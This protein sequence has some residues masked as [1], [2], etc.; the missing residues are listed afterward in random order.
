MEWEQEALTILDQI[1]LPPIMSAF[2][3][4]DAERRALQNGF[5]RVTVAIAKAVEKGY[6]RTFGKEATESIRKMAAGE[7]IDLPNEFFEEE[8]GQLFKIDICPAKYGA[9]TSEKRKMLLNIISPIRSKL[10]QMDAT[11]LMMSKARSPLMSH[12]VFRISLIGCPNCCMS[13]YFSDFGVICVYRIRAHEEGCTQCEACVRTCSEE[14][15]SL[16]A[17]K[18]VINYKKCVMCG[19]CVGKC[20]SGVL[21][22][23]AAGYKVMVGGSGSRRPQIA[24]TVT[25]YTDAAG[26]LGILE[27]ALQLYR[28]YPMDKKEVSFHEMIRHSGI[29]GLM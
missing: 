13:P 5:D 18:P 1:P 4:L 19:G 28:Q 2:A 9:C 6:A 8:E 15:I 20:G 23:E 10:Q 16:T 3:K 12:H 11:R 21:F 14:A 25:E 17:G 27:R 29:Q 22:N 26:V 24:R 7:T